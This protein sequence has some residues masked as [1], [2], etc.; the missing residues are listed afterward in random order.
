[1]LHFLA[2][3]EHLPLRGF[4]HPSAVGTS[5]PLLSSHSHSSDGCVYLRVVVLFGLIVG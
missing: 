1:M 3:E 2:L 5:D 4:L